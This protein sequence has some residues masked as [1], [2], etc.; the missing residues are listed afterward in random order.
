[1]R[2]AFDDLGTRAKRSFVR[3]FHVFGL[4]VRRLRPPT[5]PRASMGVGLAQI[6]RL[7]FQPET[8]IDVGVAYATTELYDAFP[9]AS[10]LLVEPLAEFE[11]FLKKICS[12]YNAQYVLAAAGEAPG[13]GIIHVHE[14][15]VGSS[16]LREIEGPSV[17]GVSRT[18][19]I[20]TIDQLCLEKHLKPPYLVKADVQGAELRVLTGASRTLQQTGAVILEVSLVAALIEGPEFFEVVCRMKELGFVAYDFLGLLYRPLDDALCQVDVLFVPDHSPLRESHAYATPEQRLEL[21]RQ[22][23]GAFS[24]AQRKLRKLS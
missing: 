6:A 8:V 19:P 24:V 5:P 4:D 1:M 18:I 11:P 7:G 23:A 3:L 21:T 17:D 15:G 13:T 16:L 10:L 12:A 9:S 20:V 2:T 14:D 22:Y